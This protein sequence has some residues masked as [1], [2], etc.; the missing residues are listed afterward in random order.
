MAEK[1]KTNWLNGLNI[2]NTFSAKNWEKY[3][4]GTLVLFLI[5]L[6]RVTAN[7]L[8]V[9]ENDYKESQAQLRKCNESRTLDAQGREAVSNERAKVLDEYVKRQLEESA[10]KYFQPKIDS[11]NKL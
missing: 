10:N 8:E 4:L 6:W 11:L 9:K 3:T 7:Q 5:F 1:E 2:F